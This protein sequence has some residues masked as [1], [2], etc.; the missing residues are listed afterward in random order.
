[1]STSIP[2]PSIGHNSVDRAKLKDIISRIEG[3]ES[4]RAELA[5]DVKDILAEPKGSGFAR[6]GALADHQDAPA[7]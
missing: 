6:R 7:G 1:M 2:T 5:S 3:I 4:E